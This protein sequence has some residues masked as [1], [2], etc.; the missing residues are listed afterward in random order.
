MLALRHAAPVLG[1]IGQDV[2]L[3]NHDFVEVRRDCAGRAKPGDAPTEDNGAR[4][5][6]RSMIVT[7]AWPPPS[8]M[9]CRP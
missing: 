8:H 5:D 9:V 1:V 6:K 3:K 4:H 7:F 2:T